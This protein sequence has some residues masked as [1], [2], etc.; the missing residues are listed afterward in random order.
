VLNRTHDR[1]AL[2]ATTGEEHPGV[3]Q[4]LRDLPVGL[5][6][7][8]RRDRQRARRR[9]HDDLGAVLVP[10]DVGDES[11]VHEQARSLRRHPQCGTG[12][13]RERA[14]VPGGQHVDLSGAERDGLRDRGVVGDAAVDELT[15]GPAHRWEHARDR[16]AGHDGVEGGTGGQGPAPRR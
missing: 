13:R 14:G 4:C 1:R 5:A 8:D 11:A 6:E 12:R 9:E 7:V 15:A 3:G 16:G 2:G 10:R